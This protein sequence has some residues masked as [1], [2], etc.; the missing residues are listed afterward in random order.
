MEYDFP[1]SMHR[2]GV[3]AALTPKLSGFLIPVLVFGWV[4]LGAAPD[5]ALGQVIDD[6]RITHVEVQADFRLTDPLGHRASAKDYQGKALL[7]VFGYTSCPDVCP[8]ILVEVARMLKSLKSDAGAAGAARALFITLDPER[9]TP[10][11]TGAFVRNFHE[12]IIGLTGS[13]EE[14]SAA[15]EQ[16]GVF[17]SKV[18]TGSA[19]GYA[20]AHTGFIY[21]VDR[22]GI[23]R[24]ALPHDSRADLMLAGMK[25]LLAEG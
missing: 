4:L 8:V 15:A 13:K 12:D 17:Y 23:V 1:K 3:M 9:D 6:Y 5:P 10:Q 24:Y 19:A 25:R 21:L 7:I 11:L 18:E 22:Q 20:I 2:D 16:F 14:I